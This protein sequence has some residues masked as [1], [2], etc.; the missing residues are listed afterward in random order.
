MDERSVIE[1]DQGAIRH[2]LEAL[3]ELTGADCGLCPILKADAYGF[4]AVRVARAA[5]AAGADMLAVFEPAEAAT[6]FRARVDRAVLVLMPV[7]RL[8]ADRAIDRALAGGRLHLTCHGAA[9]LQELLDLAAALRVTLPVHLEVDTGMGRGGCGLDET[10][11]VLRRIAG[12]PRLRLAGVMTHFSKA[13]DDQAFTDRQIEHIE[14]LLETEGALIGPDC[15]VHAANTCGTLRG[16]RYHK[17]LV[18]IGLG[19]TGFG[20]EWIEPGHGGPPPS[21]LR[22]ALRWRSAIMHARA[23]APGERVGY[24]AAW[25]A[26]RPTL[27]ALVPVGY[28]D[29]YPIEL[30]ATDLRREAGLVRVVASPGRPLRTGFAPVIGAINMDQVV[31]DLTDLAVPGA[32]PGGV[33]DA[34]V[35]LIGT[36][37][38]APN[39][40]FALAARS[41]RIPHELLCRLHPAIRRVTV[42]EVEPAAT[43][44]SAPAP[45]AP[46]APAGTAR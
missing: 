21:A 14:R 2:N 43:P 17:R 37:P 27:A 13:R 45:V 22:P 41:G 1:I 20:P 15:Y 24:G 3:D 16:R 36:D 42:N 5:I 35:E 4:G 26:R 46:S 33:M 38:E 34:V 6:L 18:R 39:N 12:S 23:L 9:H 8:R 44:W 7:R 11:A 10:P 28:A 32:T 25:T 40:L 19:W 31:I 29:G 30:G